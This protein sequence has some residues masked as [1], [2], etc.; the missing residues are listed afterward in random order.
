MEQQGGRQT[1]ALVAK[2]YSPPL[3]EQDWRRIR[4]RCRTQSTISGVRTTKA[5]V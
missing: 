1:Q 5:K 2:R 3:A 4:G